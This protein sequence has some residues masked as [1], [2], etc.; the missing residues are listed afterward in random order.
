[1]SWRVTGALCGATAYGLR[2]S[3]GG[4]PR[5]TRGRIAAVITCHDLGRTLDEALESVERQTRPA[6]EIVV[7][8]DGSTDIYTRQVLARLEEASDARRT[9][10][11]QRRVGGAQSSARRLTSADYL[12]WLDADDM[13]EPGYFEA[14]AAPA[15]RRIPSLDFVSCAMRAFGAA[16]YVWTPARCRRSSTRCRPGRAARVDDAAAA[17]V[18]G[19]RRIRRDARVVRAAGLLGVRDRTGLPRRHSRRAAA[20][21]P[22]PRRDR[23]TGV[24]FSRTRIA[25]RLRHFYAKHRAAVERHGL[26][27]IAGEGSVPPQPARL[28]TRRSKLAPASLEAELRELQRSDRRD[29][30][31]NSNRAACRGSNG[32]TSAASSRSARAGGRDRGTPIDRHYIERFLDEHRADIRGRVLEVRDAALHAAV[33]RR[34][35]H[36]QRRR[37]HRFDE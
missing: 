3:T 12:V 29:H 5:M 1:M 16:S 14:A 6:A 28:P 25:T 24:R 37:R 27:L 30:S 13:L 17:R 31:R 7:V 2:G 33:R 23:A 20:Q 19:G 15:R 35:R 36:L 22:R 21:L 9:G 26:D 4:R 32:A 11:R 18:G 10:R 34:R 8:D